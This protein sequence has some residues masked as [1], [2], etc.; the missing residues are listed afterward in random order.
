MPIYDFRCT[1]CKWKDDLWQRGPEPP[2]CPKCGGVTRQKYHAPN[3][4]GVKDWKEYHD[5]GLG[6][7]V[8]KMEDINKRL[9]A[10][11]RPKPYKT[12][13]PE[14]GKEM[15]L[16]VPGQNLVAVGKVH[17]ADLNPDDLDRCVKEHETKVKKA[18]RAM[19]MALM[20]GMGRKR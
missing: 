2:K 4:L 12:R 8:S 3:V 13:D 6:I 5:P 18:K 9:A 1:S 7:N 17:G 16:E 10:L 19:G 20:A 14:T 15:T 11:R